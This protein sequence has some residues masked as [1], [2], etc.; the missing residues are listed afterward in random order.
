[1][2][3]MKWPKNLFCECTKC[4]YLSKS[5]LQSTEGVH[6]SPDRQSVDSFTV[7]VNARHFCYASPLVSCWSPNFKHGGFSE[8]CRANRSIWNWSSKSPE[9]TWYSNHLH[10]DDHGLLLWTASIHFEY[11]SNYRTCLSF[12]AFIIFLRTSKIYPAL[13][14]HLSPVFEI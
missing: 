2:T 8:C 4:D 12:V 10:L 9:A 11:L 3:M 6:L 1:M 14:I 5:H 13:T 7:H